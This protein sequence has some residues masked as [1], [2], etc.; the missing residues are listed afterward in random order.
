MNETVFVEVEGQID[1]ILQLSEAFLLH[2]F[3]ELFFLRTE[4]ALHTLGK[5]VQLVQIDEAVFQMVEFFGEDNV[6]NEQFGRVI[7]GCVYLH[8]R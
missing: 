7:V 6:R 2:G 3:V 1:E 8:E 4:E 5:V